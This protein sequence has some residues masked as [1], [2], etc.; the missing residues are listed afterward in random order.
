MCLSMRLVFGKVSM[1]AVSVR[2]TQDLSDSAESK[3]NNVTLQNQNTSQKWT[4]SVI[5]TR[6]LYTDPI[7]LNI[8]IIPES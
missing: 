4:S 7:K 2:W 5:V 3:Y 1:E 8:R 6:V